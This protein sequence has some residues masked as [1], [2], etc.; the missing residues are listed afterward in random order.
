MSYDELDKNILEQL[1]IN[2][3]MKAKDLA[4]VLEVRKQEVNSRLYGPLQKKCH[5]DENF[6]WSIRKDNNTVSKIEFDE[7][8]YCS[9]LTNSNDNLE[10]YLYS[11]N[12]NILKTPHLLF[13]KP[14]IL[15]NI[16]SEKVIQQI[17]H[18]MKNKGIDL[19]SNDYFLNRNDDLK[20]IDLIGGCICFSI[21][22]FVQAKKRSL[23]EKEI[24]MFSNIIRIARIMG[25]KFENTSNGSKSTNNL[26]FILISKGHTELQPIYDA[27]F[28]EV[29]DEELKSENEE[30]EKIYCKNMKQSS[31]NEL[32]VP[33]QIACKDGEKTSESSSMDENS[34]LNKNDTLNDLKVLLDSLSINGFIDKSFLSSENQ[35]GLKLQ[36]FQTEFN[37][38]SVEELIEALGLKVGVIEG[39]V[40]YDLNKNDADDEYRSVF[41]AND[42]CG[43]FLNTKISGFSN[44]AYNRLMSYGVKTYKDLLNLNLEEFMT[45]RGVGVGVLEE[46]SKRIQEIQTELVQ[47]QEN[48]SIQ[49]SSIKESPIEF[50]WGTYFRENEQFKSLF[51]VIIP[52][53]IKKEE[54]LPHLWLKSDN[55][56]I[57]RNFIVELKKAFITVNE[58][59]EISINGLTKPGDIGAFFSMLNPG[60]LVKISLHGKVK[61][62]ILELLEEALKNFT[63]TI[64]IGKGQS[65]RKVQVDLPP[66]T[67]FIISSRKEEIS[68]K[69]Q[70]AIDLIIESEIPEEELIEIT[71]LDSALNNN[72]K[73]TKETLAFLIQY[74]ENKHVNSTIKYLSD[75]LYLNSNS[76]KILSIKELK[77]ILNYS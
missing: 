32:D 27:I 50:D 3:P 64:V 38:N 41:E 2:G 21:Y 40:E 55:E 62:E 31:N 22:Y 19:N 29:E 14:I 26:L 60:D 63:L 75:Y 56:L 53:S 18:F 46:V 49:N 5:L 11:L 44:R 69:I 68:G 16:L 1:K 12:D 42:D 52:T 73:L 35:L 45:K 10:H 65:A 23:Q 39:N 48:E 8:E 13:I 51:N 76:Q 37:F 34:F 33:N 54:V 4:K 70:N 6:Y 36:K 25:W 58:Y 17:F 47:N 66:F 77:E 74:T 57:N 15:G 20:G 28:V 72:L 30:L 71:I 24:V 7:Q 9:I 61:S 67:A 59:N 43:E